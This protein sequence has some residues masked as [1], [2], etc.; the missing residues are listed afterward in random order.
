MTN[1]FLKLK[2]VPLRWLFLAVILNG[3]G[4]VA[5][6]SIGSSAE[7]MSLSSRFFKHL[8]WLFPSL[9][10]F[11]FFLAIP[12]RI[13]HKYAYGALVVVFAGLFLPLVTGPVAGT[14]RWISL[15]GVSFQPSEIMKWVIVIALARYLSDHNLKL[16]RIQSLA[17]PIMMAVIPAAVIIRQPDLGS[18]IIVMAPVIPLLYWVGARPFHIFV[19]MAPVLTVVTAFNYYSF[20][21][22]VLLVAVVL[23]QSRTTFKVKLANF[24][25]NIFIGLFTPFLWGQLKPYQQERLRVLLDVSRDPRGAAYQVIQSQTAIGSGGLLGKGW[26]NGTQTH[27]KF[28]PEQ[29]TDFIFSVVGEELGFLVVCLILFLFAILILDLIKAAYHSSERFS[30]LVL[31]GIATLFLSHIFVNIGM[32]INLLPVKGLPLP[33]LSYGGSFLVSC[34]AMIGLAMNMSVEIQE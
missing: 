31:I 15:G 28:L 34:Y 33:F 1:L 18:A 17:V 8:L 3:F 30:S 9:G 10:A 27:L 25:S 2:E 22:W 20:T 6:Y 26:G 4:L 19:L 16:R 5:L 12:V 13:V 29:E 21:L 24:F 14:Y 7:Q 23:Y 11:L 32:T